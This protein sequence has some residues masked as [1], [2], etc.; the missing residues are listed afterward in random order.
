M[1]VN[2][3]RV[4]S[5]AGQSGV[6]VNKDT[7]GTQQV[8]LNDLEVNGG[9]VGVEVTGNG[10]GTLNMTVNDSEILSSTAF[11]MSVDNIDAG[12]IQVNNTTF[13][14][15]N[16][17][18]GAVG[19]SIVNSNASFTFDADPTNDDTVIQEYGGTDFLVDGGTP[20]ITFNGRIV[21][22]SVTNPADTTGRSVVIQ[23]T[24]GGAK[25]FTTNSSITDNNA[26]HA[27]A[28]QLG[29][30]DQLPGYEYL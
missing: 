3:I 9:E 12:T 29:R 16:V 2:S 19:V 10:T 23:N 18:P 24:T 7:T 21:N 4:N 27:G 26:R 1:T 30:Y 11:G 8:N 6:L 14:G 25:T 17:T 15:N 13:D 22:S 5:A 28:K 20:N